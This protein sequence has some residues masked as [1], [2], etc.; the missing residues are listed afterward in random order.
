MHQIEPMDYKRHIKRI[1]EIENAYQPGVTSEKELHDWHE[2]YAAQRKPSEM[3]YSIVALDDSNAVIGYNELY[4]GVWQADG[5]FE[6]RVVVDLIR[7]RQGMGT[8][9]YDDALAFAG[10]HQAK[11]LRVSVSDDRPLFIRFAEQRGFER[12]SNSFK[13]SLDLPAFDESKLGDVLAAV[14]ALQ[15]DGLHLVSMAELGD[16]ADARRKLHRINATT[17][18]DQPDG[19][20]NAPL[21]PF[22]DFN[23]DVCEQ[24]WYRPE[25]Q[26]VAVETNSGEFVG[27]CAVSI[28]D[29]GRAYNLH[30]GVAREYRG[31]KL[32]QVLKLLAIRYARAKG[33]TRLETDNDSRNVPMLAVN[34]KFGYWRGRG[35]YQ[36]EKTL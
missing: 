19:D 24:P 31:R 18:N 11:R 36:Y 22:D 32:A 8:K 34:V 25:G 23:R 6:I 35:K 14:S 9:L 2:N 5:V 10:A 29:E 27:M 26:I 7:T 30:T 12:K 33:A 15:S 3:F 20:P 13:S 1:A 21:P 4:H 17:G 16:T 28:N